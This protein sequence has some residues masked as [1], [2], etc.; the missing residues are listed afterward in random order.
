LVYDAFPNLSG[1]LLG[2]LH[3]CCTQS[4]LGGTQTCCLLCS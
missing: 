3:G 1:D 4:A 2:L